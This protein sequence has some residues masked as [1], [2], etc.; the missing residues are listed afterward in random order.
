MESSEE[1]Y[2]DRM[3][4][5]QR[6]INEPKNKKKI[7]TFLE[8]MSVELGCEVELSF[9]AYPEV[10]DYDEYMGTE[11]F[12]IPR[13]TITMKL[14]EFIDHIT[15]ESR[16]YKMYIDPIYMKQGVNEINDVLITTVK[17]SVIVVPITTTKN[18]K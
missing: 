15:K 1:H 8:K 13:E 14:G 12:I 2:K 3:V 7:D 4:E 16:E 18:K 10:D 6:R 5:I 11:D 17:D 9:N